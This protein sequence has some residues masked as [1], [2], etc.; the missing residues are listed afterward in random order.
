MRVRV[1]VEDARPGDWVRAVWATGTV[2]EGVLQEG[3]DG[4]LA[5]GCVWLSDVVDDGTEPSTP[6]GWPDE[7]TV[8]RPTTTPTGLGAVVRIGDQLWV[9]TGSGWVRPTFGPPGFV[10]EDKDG[11]VM[12]EGWS[13]PDQSGGTS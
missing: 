6:A 2:V 13:G 9:Q 12:S 7:V 8:H 11:E 4:R 10:I 1:A 5:V 3:H